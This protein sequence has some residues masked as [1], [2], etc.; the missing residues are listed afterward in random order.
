M[1]VMAIPEKKKMQAL[2]ILIANESA[3]QLKVLAEVLTGLGHEVIAVEVDVEAVA[4]VTARERPDVA[5]VGLR[6]SSEHALGLIEQIVHQSS[7]PVIAL[8]SAE[9]PDY[10][11]E[12]AR[13][14]V[15]AYLVDSTPEE[16]QSAIDI[17]LQRFAEYHDLQGA[18]GRRAVIEQA[19]GILMAGH[20]IDA[21]EAFGV[22][23][24]YSQ[25]HGRKLGDVAAS[26]IESHLLLR[27]PLPP[28]LSSV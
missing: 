1:R 6:E 26:I 16:L 21:D 15:F 11:R 19:K 10:V 25:H 18:F 12:A 23:R 9:E 2:R 22:L 8:L 28:T 20:A 27:R 3:D 17:T 5:L 4:A 13:R 24:D 7:C 14:G